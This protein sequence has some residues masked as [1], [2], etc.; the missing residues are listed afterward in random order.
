MKIKTR[1]PFFVMMLL[2]IGAGNSVLAKN[3]TP[4]QFTQILND[5]IPDKPQEGTVKEVPKSKK[6]VKPEPVTGKIKSTVKPVT[7]PVIKPVI[8]KPKV[9]VKPVIKLP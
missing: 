8:V 3:S 7:T 5:T 1:V 2:G 6:Q 9:I 4:K